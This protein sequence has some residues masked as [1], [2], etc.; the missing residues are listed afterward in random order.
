MSW[1]SKAAHKIGH[2]FS[3]PFRGLSRA[4]FGGLLGLGHRSAS[5]PNIPAPA[6]AVEAPSE[7]QGQES[8]ATQTPKKK[9]RA[10]GKRALMIDTSSNN[11]SGGST[12]TGLNL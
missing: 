2:A 11:S 12:G 4:I 9:K 5:M 1:L 8:V 10:I 3:K 7:T 6:P